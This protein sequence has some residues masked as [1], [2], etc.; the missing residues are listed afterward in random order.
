MPVKKLILDTKE[1]LESST[2]SYVYSSWNISDQIRTIKGKINYLSV[3]AVEFPNSLYNITTRNNTFAWNRNGDS[4]GRTIDIPAGRYNASQ[5]CEII[6]ELGNIVEV[7][8]SGASIVCALDTVTYKIGL[9]LTDSSNFGFEYDLS[10]IGNVL[11][12]R[13]NTNATGGGSAV[14]QTLVN[15]QGPSSVMLRSNIASQGKRAVSYSG[16]R[17]VQDFLCYVPINEDFLKMVYWFN[18]NDRDYIK[19]DGGLSSNVYIRTVNRKSEDIDT[20][21]FDYKVILLIDYE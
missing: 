21:F 11:G 2:E 18:E 15:L 5:L 10:T 7:G 13:Q 8:L 17:D 19:M 9:S 1:R 12:F 4:T 16:V 20:Q 14:G 3:Y 6:E